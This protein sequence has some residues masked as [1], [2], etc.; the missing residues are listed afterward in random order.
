MPQGLTSTEA[1]LYFEA[2]IRD[3]KFAQHVRSQ[4]TQVRE[5]HESDEK[6]FDRIMEEVL[7]ARFPGRKRG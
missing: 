5:I 6:T 7:D 1:C 2:V 4:L 3:V